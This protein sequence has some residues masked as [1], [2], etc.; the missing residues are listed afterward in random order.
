M[1][2]RSSTSSRCCNRPPS[3]CTTCAAAAMLVADCEDV[4]ALAQDLGFSSH[5]HF[6][7]AFHQAYGRTPTAFRRVALSQ[8]S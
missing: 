7:A 3:Q 1:H 5:S 6:S 2:G 8:S 4:A